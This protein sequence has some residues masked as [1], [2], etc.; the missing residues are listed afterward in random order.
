M[1][2]DAAVLGPQETEGDHRARY[3]DAAHQAADEVVPAWRLKGSADLE[4]LLNAYYCE[5]AQRANGEL[6]QVLTRLKVELERAASEAAADAADAGGDGGGEGL[7]DGRGGRA[8]AGG[9]AG[10]GA[11]GAGGPA[12]SAARLDR[13]ADA[14][15]RAASVV[16]VFLDRNHAAKLLIRLRRERF[17]LVDAL[18][19]HLLVTGQTDGP[20]PIRFEA[21]GPAEIHGDPEKL[22]DVLVHL[23]HYMR[24]SA[25]EDGILVRLTAAAR[26]ASEEA[27][28]PKTGEERAEA[29]EGFIGVRSGRISAEELMEELSEPLRFDQMRISIPFARAVMERHGGTVFVARPDEETVGLGFV[30]PRAGATRAQGGGGPGPD[31]PVPGPGDGGGPDGP[32]RAD[33]RPGGVR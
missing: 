15:D 10:G 16:D 22:M 9:G 28:G 12:L 4:Q 32:P 2:T 29:V 1:E 25:G 27:Q 3:V 26:S 31:R 14:V 21:E 7:G 19:Q 33:D 18:E 17:D 24:R 5:L 20:A 8:E 11:A 23:V 13:L 6:R 30:L